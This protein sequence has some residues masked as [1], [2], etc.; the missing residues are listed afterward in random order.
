LT[1]ADL[2]KRKLRSILF[3]ESKS[4]RIGL[5]AQSRAYNPIARWQEGAL[6]S[7]I[8]MTNSKVIGNETKAN[9]GYIFYPE[10]NLKKRVQTLTN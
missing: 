4:R 1:A 3:N 7:T 9:E 6:P 10:R 2:K 5:Y 8:P